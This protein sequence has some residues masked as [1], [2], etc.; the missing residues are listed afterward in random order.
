M[1]VVPS[2]WE[3]QVGGSGVPSAWDKLEQRN[4]K[5]E[6]RKEREEQVKEKSK[7][8]INTEGENRR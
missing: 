6:G 5:K 2:T 3:V 8:F 7:G 4:R 1:P